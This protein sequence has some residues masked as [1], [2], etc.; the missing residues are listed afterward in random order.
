[1]VAA[2]TE[3][4]AKPLASVARG[5]LDLGE[6]ADEAEKKQAAAERKEYGALIDRLKQALGERVKDVRVTQRLTDS[7]ACLVADEHDISANLARILRAAGQ[8]TPTAKPIL[9]INPS[10]PIVVRLSDEETRL[11]DWA[12][13]LYEQAVLAEGAALED[14][15]GFGKRMNALLLELSAKG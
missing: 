6:L 11:D 12:A 7:P 9:E 10:H 5:G 1:M 13:L 15:A 4:G 14:P 8:K 3:F 2:L